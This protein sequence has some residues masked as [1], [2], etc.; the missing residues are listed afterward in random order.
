M[1]YTITVGMKRNMNLRAIQDKICQDSITKSMY[2]LSNL[3][4]QKLHSHLFYARD[5]I[6]TN[7]ALGEHVIIP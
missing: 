7:E 5:R 3:F 6:D 2:T 1:I 4:K